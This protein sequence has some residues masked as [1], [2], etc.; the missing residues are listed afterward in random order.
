M[1]RLENIPVE[2]DPEE[3]R[4]R[5]RLDS[6]HEVQALIETARPLVKPRAVYTVC[7]VEERLEDG[8][9]LQDTRFTSRILA[10][11]LR[12]TERAFPYVV[13]IGPEL[14]EK[15]ASSKDLLEQ[16]YLDVVGNVAVST[17]RKYLENH[18]VDRFGLGR[19]SRM[20]PGSLK[21]WPI[22][23]QKILFSVLGDVEREIGVKLTASFLMIPRKS[24]SGI[25]FP[26]E[27]PFLSCQ[28]CPRK[29]CPSRQ[30]AYDKETAA[31]YG[32]G[33]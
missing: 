28:L 1:E 3:I 22:Q 14:E 27:I 6:P 15:A 5:L 21:D 17:A 13:T 9:V 30:A 8:V 23:E 26:K 10:T 16:Y 31:K 12:D 2:L 18:L 11:N 20:S 32:V 25:Y 7:Y 24:V 33:E 29:G 19:M 4:T